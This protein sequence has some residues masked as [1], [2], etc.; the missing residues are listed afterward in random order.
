MSTQNW[1]EDPLVAS[2]TGEDGYPP[3]AQSTEQSPGDSAGQSTTSA[4]KHEAK[5]V[6]REGVDSAKNV[7]STAGSEAKNVAHEA[8]AQARNLLGELG[9]DLKS[10]AGTQ[11]QRV[12]EGLRSLSDELRSMADNSEGGTAQQLVQQAAQR[13]GN[14]ASWLDGRDPGSLLD[15][16]TGFARRRPGTF[17]LI[18]AGAG[19][20]AGRLAR[21]LQGGND[22][23]GSAAAG[24]GTQGAGTTGTAGGQHTATY[25]PVPDEYG[26][27]APDYDT[28]VGNS[29][30]VP[31]T[32]PPAAPATPFTEPQP[33]VPPTEPRRDYP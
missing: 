13:T 17:L 26:T 8:G 30:T 23:G 18:A 33:G 1:S 31:P 6:G 9:S 21:G 12:S 29:P 10:Q 2:R 22:T 7:A 27:G 28:G 5:D 20:L 25:P 32:A 16:V 15:E 24:G 11:Q 3:P 14:A 19:L 4:A